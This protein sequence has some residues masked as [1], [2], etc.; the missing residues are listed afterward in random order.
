MVDAPPRFD[1]LWN[2]GDPA[3]TEATFR[4]LGDEHPDAGRGWRLELRT[5][6]ARALGLQQRFDEAHAELDAVDAELREGDDRVCVRAWLERG[7]A[8]NS[9][10][11]P[12]TAR[13]LF[14]RA[15]TLA[16]E[17]GEDAL[18]VDAAH[19]VAIVAASPEEALAWNERAL[20]HAE[21]SDDPGARRWLG[22]LYNNVGWT[23]HGA[24]R[25]DEAHAAFDRS[26]AAFEE[27]G[28]APRVRIARWAMARTRRSQERY[29]EALAQQRALL[30]ELEALGETDGFV[31]EE[32]G[33]NLLALGRDDE[34]GPWFGRAWD[35][36]HEDPWL[37]RDE[38]DRL[39]RLRTL[40]GRPRP[41]D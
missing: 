31:F 18:A 20:A 24:G 34:A 23:H 2:Y 35:A 16:R 17:V 40:G 25:L 3:G 7:R 1:E 6:I 22:S 5:Q 32:L 19:M 29:E 26:R 9:S 10:G 14:E 13:P 28:A 15:W 12:E 11:A 33:E 30:E 41:G 38:P 4:A 37:A 39:E 8:H 27:L 36:L 21:A